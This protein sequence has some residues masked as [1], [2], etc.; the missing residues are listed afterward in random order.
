LTGYQVISGNPPQIF[1]DPNAT[2]PNRL[3]IDKP[4]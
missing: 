4:E 3:Y 2:D 1:R